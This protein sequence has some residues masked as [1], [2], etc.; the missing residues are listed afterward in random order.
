MKTFTNFKGIALLMLL[1]VLTLSL[2]AQRRYKKQR[3][4]V[5]AETIINSNDHNREISKVKNTP[6]T[7]EIVTEESAVIENENTINEVTVVSTNS[8]VDI[9]KV[10]KNLR[11]EV[12]E[13]KVK[14]YDK[15]DLFSFT[16]RLAN[17]NKVLKV[18]DV[19]KTA[20]ETW[21]LIMIILYVAFV[22]FLILALV[23]L[24]AIYSYGAYLAFIILA[25][26]CGIGASIVLT[27]GLIGVF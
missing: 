17:N 13:T 20:L 10:R 9:K 4:K 12:K 19:E 14:N 23:F 24:Y 1:S 27:L 8:S 11:K 3:V 21:V 7:N 2:N 22:V 25:I 18:Q 15:N 16:K 5:N 26:L 6:V